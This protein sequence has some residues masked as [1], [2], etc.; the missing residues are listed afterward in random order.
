MNRPARVRFLCAL[1]L[2]AGVL[3][4]CGRRSDATASPPAVSTLKLVPQTVADEISVSGTIE[5]VDKAQLAFLVPGR[6]LSVEVQDG[7]A[8]GAGQLLARLDDSDYRH[9][10]AIADAKLAEVR[11]R[12]ARLRQMH[13]LGSL[14]ATDFDKITAAL[15]EAKSAA[16]LA[17]RRLGYT[18]LRA[19]FSGLVTRH[20]V[21]AGT[22]VAPGVPVCSV[23]APAPVWATV[24]VPE[25]E[26]TRLRPGLPLQVRLA[27]AEQVTATAPIEAI[28]PQA[29]AITRSF[30]VKARLENADHA[31]RPGNVITGRITVGAEHPVLTLPPT[32]V[33]HFPD[34]ALFVWIVDPARQTVTR[35]IVSIGRTRG[36]EVEVV[37]G[38]QA[39]EVVVT[40]V[41][42]P[43]FDGMPVSLGTP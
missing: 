2:L 21:A 15:T 43:L 14:T 13:D 41:A 35:R 17:H 30:A 22:V 8:V 29:D 3:A 34:G 20:P 38:L 23:L 36:T 1:A 4:G 28:L 33:Q 37:A 6:V 40:G 42:A 39:G 18:E 10:V 27:A 9:E 25:V 11:A 19:P 5:A 7:A 26:A 16:A 24:S 12:E 31:F 32:A